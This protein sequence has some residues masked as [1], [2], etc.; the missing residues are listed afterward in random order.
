[1]QV[2]QDC[3]ITLDYHITDLQGDVVDEGRMPLQY[4]HGGYQGIFAK[5]EDALHEKAIGEAVTVTLAPEEAFGEYDEELVEVEARDKFPDELAVGMQFE[6]GLS[7]GDA[8]DFEIYH[9]TDIV[10]D[11]VVLDGNHPLAGLTLVFHCTVTAVRPASAQEIAAGH[12]Q[13]DDDGA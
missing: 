6:G 11:K 2:A 8:E 4:L 5:I 1:M 10:G 13:V 12:I 9:V 3:V 7:G